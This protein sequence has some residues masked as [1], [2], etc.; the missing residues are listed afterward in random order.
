MLNILLPAV[1]VSPLPAIRRRPASLF[2]P[3]HHPVIGH[4]DWVE[5]M[6]EAEFWPLP[7]SLGEVHS[8]EGTLRVYDNETVTIAVK[9]LYRP[10]GHL[11]GS[12]HFQHAHDQAIFAYVAWEE[13]A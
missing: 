6:K 11:S 4:T 1:S 2:V 10:A 7:L 5:G 12:W 9:E 8:T 3:G 13:A